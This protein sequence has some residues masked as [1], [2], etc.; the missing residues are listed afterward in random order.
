MDYIP[1]LPLG[2]GFTDQ[3]CVPCWAAA[4]AASVVVVLATAV[5]QMSSR[6]RGLHAQLDQSM[7]DSS[8]LSELFGSELERLRAQLTQSQEDSE[9]L[10]E[11]LGSILQGGLPGHLEMVS[12]DYWCVKTMDVVYTDQEGHRRK[13]R[14][15]G[16]HINCFVPGGA[17]DIE[18]SFRVVGGAEVRQV[19]RS[20]RNCPWVHDE[21]GKTRQEK[22]TYARCPSNVR[23]EIRGASLGAFISRVTEVDDPAGGKGRTQAPLVEGVAVGAK[24]DAPEGKGSGEPARRLP[25][26]PPLPPSLPPPPG[27]GPA[28]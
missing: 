5:W 12:K 22:F 9:S 1:A 15:S 13:W 28:A 26:R 11:I 27:V 17:R 14:Q 6:I 19:D 3:V 4:L 25:P 10:D 7:E 18:V 23:F 2:I 16:Y 24:R 21:R 8:S 20:K